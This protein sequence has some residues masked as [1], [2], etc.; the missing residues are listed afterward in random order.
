MENILIKIGKLSLLV[1]CIIL[2]I[3]IVVLNNELKMSQT[4]TETDHLS[5]Q[6]IGVMSGWESDY[7]LSDRED[8]NLKRYDSTADLFMALYFNQVDAVAIDQG[9]LM[10]AN[11]S[12]SGIKAVGKPLA[13]TEYTIYTKKGNDKLLNEL[14]SFIEYFKNSDAYDEYVK[15]FYDLDWLNKEDMSKQSGTGDEIIVGYV[16]D[17]YPYEYVT[18]NDL[19]AGSEVE[20][21]I[22]FA[23]YY[24]YK[25]KWVKSTETTIF[26]DIAS[27]KVDFGLC[28]ATDAYREETYDED[29]RLDMSDGYINSNIYCVVQ[30]GKM[31]VMNT[32]FYGE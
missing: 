7:F 22:R 9:T 19:P 1:V 31:N 2:F 4:L 25:I 20:F 32:D 28:C 16:I 10:L 3:G 11:N 12:I 26:T 21:A 14:N 18:E 30:D 23:N 27:G 29:F 13:K 5:G 17:Y 8:I 6:R 15:H 24:N